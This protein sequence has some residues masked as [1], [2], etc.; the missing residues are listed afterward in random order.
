MAVVGGGLI[1][2]RDGALAQLKGGCRP[3]GRQMPRRFSLALNTDLGRLRLTAMSP[4]KDARVQTYNLVM[5]VALLIL[6]V[7]SWTL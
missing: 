2:A 6:P 3:R 7:R 5:C 1:A 4:G